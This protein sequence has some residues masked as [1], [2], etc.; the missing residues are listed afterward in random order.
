[1]NRLNEDDKITYILCDPNRKTIYGEGPTYN[2]FITYVKRF[3]APYMDMEFSEEEYYEHIYNEIWNHQH[4][5]EQLPRGHSKTELVGIWFTIYIVDYQPNNPFYLKYKGTQKRMTEQLLLAGAQTDL[6]AWTDR[7]K[8]FFYK[9]PILVRLKPAGVDKER[10]SNRW[11]NKEMAFKNGSKLHLR[12]VKGKIR[13]THNDRV[14]ADDLITESSTL[15]DNQ[16]IDVWDSAVDGTTTAKEAMVQVIGTPKRYTD[17]MFHLKNKPEG[18]FFRARPAI[19]DEENKIVL[20][21]NRRDYADLMRTKGRIG[22]TVFSAEYLLNPI[23]DTI[24]LIKRAHIE[25]CLDVYLEGYWLKPNIRKIGTDITVTFDKLNDFTFKRE[26]W[27]SV[28]VTGDFAFSDRR[29]ADASVFSYY[30]IRGGKKY[31]LG[32]VRGKGWSPMTQ[33]AI[34]KGLQNYLKVSMFGLEENSIKGVIKDVKVLNLPIKLYWMGAKDK[35]A[36]HKPEVPFSSKRI[37]ISKILGIERLDASYENRS[38]VIP[39]KTQIDKERA[40]L[41]IEESISWALDEGKLVEIGR[42]PDI[43]ITDMLVNEMTAEYSGIID[44]A[45]TG[46]GANIDI[47]DA[48]PRKMIKKQGIYGEDI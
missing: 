38:F 26:E 7:I 41:Q 33:F 37:I 20:S 19:L 23:D 4:T 17:I 43:P 31:R 14:V 12:T 24:S 13:G 21:P 30:G 1:M 9:A 8:D 5:V 47:D 36:T 39:Y 34:L 28:F 42:H 40:D 11:N 3:L 2:K 6:D 10:T 32:Y 15:T 48:L 45:V 25:G 35:A 46:S 27:D 29:T 44:M 22:S 16:T 18:Y